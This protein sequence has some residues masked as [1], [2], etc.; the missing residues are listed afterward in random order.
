MRGTQ[1]IILLQE[2]HCG[3][4]PAH[5]GNTLFFVLSPVLFWDHPRACGEHMVGHLAG[6]DSVGSSPR[7][8]GT[9]R[10]AWNTIAEM[11]I[12]PAHAGN[13]CRFDSMP[14]WNWDHPRACGEHALMVSFGAADTGSSP[15]MRGTRPRSSRSAVRHG[16]IP[17]HAGNTTVDYPAVF[18]F[19]GSSPRMRG[20]LEP[21]SLPVLSTGIIPAHAGNTSWRSG[22][23]YPAWDHPR[24]CGEHA[25]LESKADN[26]MGSSPRMRGTPKLSP[27]SPTRARII[28]AHAGNT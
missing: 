23:M 7:M 28:P 12:I 5:A 25:L 15:R 9:L 4:I 3:I 2:V 26:A 1:H 27:S 10:F 16:I 24:A 18:Y 11:G 14:H 21:V 13:T 8:R 20:T 17:A 19:P 6:T 22:W